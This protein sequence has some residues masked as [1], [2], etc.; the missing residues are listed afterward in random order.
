M[1]VKRPSQDDTATQSPNPS[2]GRLMSHWPLNPPPIVPS[3][4]SP[5]TSSQLSILNPSTQKKFKKY[6]KI[7][8]KTK[9]NQ[10]NLAEYETV[11]FLNVHFQ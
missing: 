3:V 8:K 4:H 11:F 2:I 5:V 10:Y 7:K 9:K 6:K 1:L